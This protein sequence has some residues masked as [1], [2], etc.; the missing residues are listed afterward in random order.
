[1]EYL[2]YITIPHQ[3]MRN[4][5]LKQL[6]HIIYGIVYTLS[7]M[8]KKKCIA[9]NATISRLAITTPNTVQHSLQRLEDEGYIKRNYKDETNRVRVSIE[10]LVVF[11]RVLSPDNTVLLPDNT[12][13]LPAG[14]QNNKHINNKDNSIYHTDDPS[15][16]ATESKVNQKEVSSLLGRWKEVTLNF[17]D[18][19]F[20]IKSYRLAVERLV[21]KYGYEDMNKFINKFIEIKDDQWTPD[22]STPIRFENNLERIAKAIK[23]KNNKC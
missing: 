14:N 13:V 2:D 15:S 7:N 4:K 11:G 21:E 1:M 22:G 20:K 5:K 18:N 17:S 3:V 16:V 10:P 9:S 8:S 6:D 23:R 19:Y 12:Q